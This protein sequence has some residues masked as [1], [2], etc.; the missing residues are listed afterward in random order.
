LALELGGQVKVWR[1]AAD[2]DPRR[3]VRGVI[4]NLFPGQETTSLLISPEGWLINLFEIEASEKGDL[5]GPPWC[6]VKTQFGPVEGHVALVELLAALKREFFADLEV[7]D[8]GGYWETRDLPDLAAKMKHVQAA[9]DG[10]AEGIRRYG[11]SPEAAE[12]REI[13][14]ARIER[15]ARLVHRTLSRPAEHPPVHWDDDELDAGDDSDGNRGGDESQWDA[16]YKENRRRQERMHRAI[17]EHLAQGDDLDEAMDAA[18][19]EETALGLPQ[20]PS[21]EP[22]DE[23]TEDDEAEEP[24]MEEDDDEADEPWK[25]SPTEAACRGDDEFGIPD[26]PCHPLQQRAFDLMLRLHGLFK[27]GTESAGSHQEVLLYGAG[28]I[29][30]GLV[31]ALGREPPFSSDETESLPFAAPEWGP[32]SGLSIVQLKRAMRGAAFA[33]GALFPLKAGGALDEAAFQELHAAID[34]LQ[35]GIYTELARLRQRRAGES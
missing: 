5:A 8:E 17:E 9:I 33:L 2:D 26:R 16:L 25:E 34:H 15:I 10:L 1:S 27:D 22:D 31:Q 28:E 29:V 21:D 12:D 6:F 19:H 18:M 35:T 4:L 23:W 3:V 14:L 24:W 32:M 30:G 7:Q 11:L 13:L 20:D